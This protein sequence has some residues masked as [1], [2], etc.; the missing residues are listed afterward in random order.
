MHTRI[1]FKR[2]FVHSDSRPWLFGL[3][4]CNA[5]T[6]EFRDARQASRRGLGVPRCQPAFTSGMP[7]PFGTE[8]SSSLTISG[9]GVRTTVPQG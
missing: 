5:T 2:E 1:S 6:L 9:T 7:W 8:P 4:T 3:S